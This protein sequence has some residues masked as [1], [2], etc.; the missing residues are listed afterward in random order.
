ME[1]RGTRPVRDDPDVVLLI[2]RGPKGF[3]WPDYST[4]LFP[5]T[6]LRFKPPEDLMRR[7]GYPELTR[8]ADQSSVP[9]LQDRQDLPRAVFPSLSGAS[10]MTFLP[11]QGPF[12][13]F[14]RQLVIALRGDRAPYATSGKPFKGPVGYKVVRVDVESDQKVVHDFIRNTAGV[15]RSRSAK[16]NPDMLERPID[17]KLGPD[18]YLYVLDFGK[19]DVR[20]G[21]ESVG[22]TTGQVFRLLPA[23]VPS[24]GPTPKHVEEP[25][26]NK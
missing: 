4:D 26:Y 13:E 22:G 25:E 18:G 24:T 17:V 2:P 1:L 3:G 11:E 16:H 5:I 14:H 15:P 6:D 10:K 8:V 12:N 23:N 21:K 19:L 7:S 9:D 20:N